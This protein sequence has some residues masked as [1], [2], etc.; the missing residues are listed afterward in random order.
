MAMVLRE[1]THGSNK[2]YQKAYQR[3][4]R[5]MGNLVLL[6]VT[7]LLVFLASSVFVGRLLTGVQAVLAD[8]RYGNPH[9]TTTSGYAFLGDRPE[10][11]TLVVALNLDGQVHILVIPAS[12]M[13]RLTR[14]E[15]PY[16]F[17]DSGREVPHI[18]LRD[19]NDDERNDL[20]LSVVGEQVIYLNR[21]DGNF[22]LMTAAERQKMLE[23]QAPWDP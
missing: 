17:G 19:M 23:S 3:E 21:V 22:G 12:D 8:M 7:Y 20:V 9:L 5:G 1:L 18:E 15:G 13:N 16:L 2:A 4:R 10:A 11:P 6:V 14:L